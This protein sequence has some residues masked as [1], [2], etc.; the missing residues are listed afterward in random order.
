VLV[1]RNTTVVVVVVRNVGRLEVDESEL[2][3]H[4]AP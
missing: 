4:F 2:E 1:E 3:S